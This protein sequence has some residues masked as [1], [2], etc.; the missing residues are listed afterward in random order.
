[1]RHG[2]T[3]KTQYHAIPI[4]EQLPLMPARLGSLLQLILALAAPAGYHRDIRFER[5]LRELL[6]FLFTSGGQTK[7]GPDGT[8]TKSRK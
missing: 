2:K 4:K 7:H 6:V 8:K 5:H 3:V 1:M